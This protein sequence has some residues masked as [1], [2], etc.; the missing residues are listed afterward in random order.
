[1]KKVLIK[2]RREEKEKC[3]NLPYDMDNANDINNGVFREF[4]QTID[5]SEREMNSRD[6]ENNYKHTYVNSQRIHTDRTKSGI[7][8]K[9]FSRKR[10]EKMQRKKKKQN[11]N[12]RIRAVEPWKNLEPE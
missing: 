11:Q 1:M 12:I 2:G 7:H 9:N 8:M 5:L 4:F 3:R 10:I 6:L